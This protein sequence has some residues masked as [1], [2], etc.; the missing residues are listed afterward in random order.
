MEERK[1]IQRQ[2]ESL[3]G[4]G[5]VREILSLC[6]M[7]VILVNQNIFQL[8]KYVIGKNLKSWEE[9]LPHAEF[10]YNRIVNSPTYSL[11]E[12]VY[13][14][15]LL[16]PL[17]LLPLPKN[18]ATMNMDWFLKPILLRVCMRRGKHKLRKR[19]NNMID[20]PIRGERK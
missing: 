15:S 18:F 17:N 1:E 8:L 10:P 11:F 19:L 7:F 3:I 9:C 16:S 4:K 5:W 20:I 2:V 6:A 14:S 12:V 13:G